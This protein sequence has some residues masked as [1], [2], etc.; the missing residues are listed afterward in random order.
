MTE[1]KV[2]SG[3][4]EQAPTGAEHQAAYGTPYPGYGQ[5]PAPTGGSGMAITALVLAIVSLLLCWVPIV[6]NLFAITAIVAIVLGLIAA[7]RAK[8]RKASGLGMARAGWIVGLVALIGVLGTQAFY[9]AVLDS[10]GDEIERSADEAKDELDGDSAA[11]DD[12]VAEQA[13]ADEAG[14]VLA[15]GEV[16][17][18]GD[19]EVAV[20]A[21]DLDA[22]AAIAAANMF[23]ESADGVYVLATVAVTYVGAAEGTP[24]LDLSTTF[25][26][27]DARN[28]DTSS[29]QAVTPN[30]SHEVPDLTNGGQATFDVCFDVA[31]EALAAPQVYVEESFAFDEARTYWSVG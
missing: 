26:G 9:A 4:T 21:V 29:C 11:T 25:V 15:I 7:R 2:P 12:D 31:A 28:Y 17:T 24:W 14:D 8:K 23:N 18:L 13:A 6:N 1:Q 22:S 3:T 10:V 27:S 20:T 19:Y 30:P 16:A 5:Q